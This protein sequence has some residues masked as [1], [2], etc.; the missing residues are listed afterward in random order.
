MAELRAAFESWGFQNVKTLLA[1]GNVL[2]D[3]P[4][5]DVQSLTQSIEEKLKE[6]FGYDIDVILRTIEQIRELVDSTPF[7]DIEVTP[8]TRLYVTFLAEKPSSGL[9]IPYESP[10][11]EFKILDVADGAVYSVLTL[12]ANTRS[13][14]AMGIL[15]KEFG[16]KI[17][18][19]N[20]NTIRKIV[21]S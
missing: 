17:T 5:T 8:D 1:T 15:E 18:T 3:S 14:D 13:I 11:K 2:F 16:K 9:K 10:E 7:A 12:I 20:W 19:R 6:T 21:K 4:K